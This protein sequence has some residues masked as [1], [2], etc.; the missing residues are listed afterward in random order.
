MGEAAEA[1]DRGEFRNFSM[2]A[3]KEIN[4]SILEILNKS[5][6][7]NYE[8]EDLENDH[9]VCENCANGKIVFCSRPFLSELLKS[10][11]LQEVTAGILRVWID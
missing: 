4:G 10:E 3:A 1:I 8:Y 6:C 9:F 7:K 11:T 2:R 5:N